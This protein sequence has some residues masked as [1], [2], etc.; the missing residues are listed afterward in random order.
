MKGQVRATMRFPLF[1]FALALATAGTFGLGCDGTRRDWGTCYQ[2]LCGPGHGCT[3]DHRCIPFLD[4]GVR[5]TS[6]VDVPKGMDGAA[7]LPP[8]GSPMEAS[9]SVDANVDVPV[10]AASV[11]VAA[12]PALDSVTEAG[13]TGPVDSGVAEVGTV[14]ANIPDAAGTCASDNDCTGKDAPYCAQGRCVSCSTG[15][16][17]SGGTPL[18]SASHVC[19]SCAAVDAGCRAATPAC[20]A[21]SGR[22]LECLGDVDCMRNAS[23]SFCQAGTCVG[24]A[25]AGAL[26]CAGRNPASP[27]CLPSGLCAECATI[28]DCKSAS[29]PSCDPTA[30]VCVTCK[31]D[32]ECLAG[33][34]GPGV[35]MFQQDGHCATDVETVYVGKNGAG[36]C[37]DSGTG[38]AQMPY[39][40][41]QTAIGVAKSALKPVLVVMGQVS[42]F[43]IGALSAPLTIVGKSAVISPADYADGLSITRGEIYLRGLTV[44]GNPSGVTGIG[45]NAQAATGS[46]VLLHMDGCTVKDNPG[47]GILLAGASFDIRN[48]K[49]TRNGP[50]QTAGGTSWGGIRV[51]SLPAGGQ[52]SLN[53]VT[54]QGNWAPGLSCSGAIQGQGVLATDNA[55]PDIV[56]SCGSVV[57]CATPSPICGAQP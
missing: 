46:T 32:D 28:A 52:A 37:S 8:D 13:Q 15:D 49:I 30:N 47:G 35:C 44:A 12:G 21:D 51:E 25:G 2:N 56:P 24:C 36:T 45:V 16:Q 5:D 3:P 55:Q 34:G 26:A 40:T 11:D 23:K 41:A 43:S 9:S 17:C 31:R 10:S 1:V 14:D 48:S 29:K 42:G 20:E 7:A 19:V 57:S 54:I 22:C 18:C 53:L 39:C 38:S 50:A 33:V 27:V 6:Q 4:A